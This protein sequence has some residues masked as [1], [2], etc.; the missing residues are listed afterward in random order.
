MPLYFQS[1]LEASPIRSG[2]LLLPFIVTGA[3]SGVLCGFIIH[4]T[5]RFR[6]IIWIGTL[7]LTLGFGLFIS[8]DATTST[9]KAV[10]FLIVG[11]LG[12]GMLFEAPLIAIQSQVEQQDVATATATLAF[13]RN[14]ALSIST[15][16]GGTIFQN[17][18]NSRASS[19]RTAGLA[20]PLLHQLDGDNA[21]ANVMLPMTLENPAWELA[22]KKA[23]AYSMQN[24]WITY[25]V[26]A[27][28]ALAAS[29]FVQAAHLGSEHVETV[30]GLS[31]EEGG[32]HSGRDGA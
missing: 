10:C 7:L 29:V 16:L 23:F 25:T 32:V 28:L 21:M 5:G 2:L 22:A 19:L 9:P 4:Q 17:S 3:I 30:T 26:F 8:F 20:A 13:I 24:M 11:G 31:K 14:I 1:V 15:I 6:E 18:M 12:S 27:F